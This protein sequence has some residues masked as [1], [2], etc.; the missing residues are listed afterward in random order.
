MSTLTERRTSETAD[1]P[2]LA[3]P[4]GRLFQVWVIWAVLYVGPTLLSGSGEPGFFAATVDS[5]EAL[6]VKVV[7]LNIPL[8]LVLAVVALSLAQVRS[9]EAQRMAL[10]VGVVLTALIVVHVAL[11]VAVAV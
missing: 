6:W 1:S 4:L 2:F 8:Q 3:T 9:R 5:Y 11:S 10:A 7:F